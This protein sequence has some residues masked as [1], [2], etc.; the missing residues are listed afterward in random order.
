M[1]AKNR[2]SNFTAFILALV[3][4]IP[5]TANAGKTTYQTANIHDFPAMANDLGGA[6]TLT[7]TKQSA[8]ARLALS[9]LD[10]A[11]AY[12]VW[13]V[14]FNY[15]ENCAAGV[16]HCGLADLGD[17]S[18][19]AS[20]FYATG[21]VTGNDG[22]ANVTAHLNSGSLPMGIDILIPGGLKEGN[23]FGAEIHMVVRS[24]GVIIPGMVAEQIGTHMGACNVNSCEDQQALGFKP[25]D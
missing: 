6:G 13:W 16:G 5:L 1:F 24:H 3:L 20:V 17:G 8:H 7:R 11:S 21:F 9:G 4:S 10:S 22:S 12:T 18:T 14:V 23:G 25:K 15:P 19:G 2:T